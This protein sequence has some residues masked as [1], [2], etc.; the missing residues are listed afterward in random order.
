M[1]ASGK[2]PTVITLVP[3]PPLPVAVI[4]ELPPKQAIGVFD[5]EIVTNAGSMKLIVLHK[6]NKPSVAQIV[7][8]PGVNPVNKPVVFENKPPSK[9]NVIVPGPVITPCADPLFAPKQ[10][11]FV[12]VVVKVKADGGSKIENVAGEKVQPLASETV[13]L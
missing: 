2:P 6:V 3:V 8:V 4:T 5:A 10:V 7:C 13:K 12:T 1:A 9:L 11:L